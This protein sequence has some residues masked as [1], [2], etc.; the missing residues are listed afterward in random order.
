[1]NKVAG[2]AI[3]QRKHGIVKISFLELSIARVKAIDSN[4]VMKLSICSE[5][6]GYRGRRPLTAQIYP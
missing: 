2:R 4:K 3:S 6:A 5:C 1:M